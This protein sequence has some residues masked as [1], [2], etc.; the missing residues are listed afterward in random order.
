MVFEAESLPLL[1]AGVSL[2]GGMAAGALV[3]LLT[4]P[5][6]GRGRVEQGRA[7]LAVSVGV[8]VAAGTYAI[9]FVTHVPPKPSPQ[10]AEAEPYGYAEWMSRTLPEGTKAPDFTLADLRSER[11]IHFH[12]LRGRRPAV[13]VFGSFG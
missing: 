4:R 8:L 9:D 7:A 10:P 6:K 12:A 2:A 5:P 3:V 11:P 13:L 1:L